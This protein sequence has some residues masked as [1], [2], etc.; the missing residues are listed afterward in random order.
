[1]M[2]GLPIAAFGM[3]LNIQSD[4]ILIDLRKNDDRYSKIGYMLPG[5]HG[6]FSYVSCANY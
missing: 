5:N 6:M 1:M 3:A 2:V 4:Q